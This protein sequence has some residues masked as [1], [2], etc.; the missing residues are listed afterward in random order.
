MSVFPVHASKDRRDLLLQI[1]A[2]NLPVLLFPSIGLFVLI[3]RRNPISW[4]LGFRSGEK[5]GDV[6]RG[7]SNHPAVDVRMA[8]H[9]IC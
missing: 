6:L 3:C 8:I 4:P 2:T 5:C 9:V 7:M 1:I